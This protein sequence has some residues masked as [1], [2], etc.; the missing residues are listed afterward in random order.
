M[1]NVEYR[2]NKSPLGVLKD[3]V[4]KDGFKA[5]YKGLLPLT[6][7]YTFLT[8]IIQEEEDLE[9][10]PL[11]YLVFCLFAHPFMLV[12]SRV[13]CNIFGKNRHLYKNSFIAA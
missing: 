6:I 5:F 2:N 9:V 13:Q 4:I 7:G 10:W 3:L 11:T 12:S 8:N 1:R